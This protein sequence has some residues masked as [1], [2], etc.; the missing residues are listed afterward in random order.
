MFSYI[1]KN[2]RIVSLNTNKYLLQAAVSVLNS[3][4]VIKLT[5][6]EFGGKISFSEF[7]DQLPAGNFK[8]VIVAI[9]L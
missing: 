5:Q 1:K 4:V 8:P 2:A 3:T 9:Y 7:M 6:H